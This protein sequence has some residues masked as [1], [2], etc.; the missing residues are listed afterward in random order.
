VSDATN[1]VY[2]TGHKPRT[3]NV[4]WKKKS[5]PKIIQV[6]ESQKFYLLLKSV[7]LAQWLVTS[8]G[9]TWFVGMALSRFVIDGGF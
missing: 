3:L 5:V 6:K 9:N 7:G 8:Y 1:G 2:L 4:N